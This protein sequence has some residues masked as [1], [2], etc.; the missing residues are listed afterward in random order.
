MYK[1]QE[2]LSH[3]TSGLKQ[4]NPPMVTSSST[5]LTKNGNDTVVQPV[6]ESIDNSL[7]MIANQI[8]KASQAPDPTKFTYDETSG[9]YY[10]F[11]TGFYYDPHSQYYYNSLIQKYMYW[12]PVTFS[13][14]P[15]ESSTATAE[16]TT[17]AD[18]SI[19]TSTVE[20]VVDQPQDEVEVEQAEGAESKSTVKIAPTKTAA[21][22]AKVKFGPFAVIFKIITNLKNINSIY[23]I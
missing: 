11:S 10:D 16:V 17:A 1:K 12:D 21:Q 7:K 4:Q 22:I 2:I 15:V 19:T 9:Y 13:Y 18:T 3:I 20:E 23:S 8:K 6:N 5:L 14:I